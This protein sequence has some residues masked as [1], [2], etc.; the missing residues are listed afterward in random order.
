M[1]KLLS[2]SLML[3]SLAI[4]SAHAISI[5]EYIEKFG[6]IKIQNGTI[7]LSNKDLTS[8]NG[9]EMITKNPEDIKAIDLSNNKIVSV[10]AAQITMFPNLERLNLSANQLTS[11]PALN[12]PK[13]KK[14]K[15]K[16]NNIEMLSD[17]N[18]PELKKFK[19]DSNPIHTLANINMPK[20][21]KFKMKDNKLSTVYNV[22]LAPGT[23]LKVGGPAQSLFVEMD[24]E[25]EPV[26]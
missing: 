13:L 16:Q 23:T 1:K 19:A 14:L 21:K 12:L 3:S 15:I 5:A 10:S 22:K 2:I 26:K 17:L 8:I 25:T 24:V 4:C 6:P 7:N 20:L 11:F 9:I 18:F